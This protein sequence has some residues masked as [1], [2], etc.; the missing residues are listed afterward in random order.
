MTW[1]ITTLFILLV[2]GSAR[3]ILII[4]AM[5]VLVILIFTVCGKSTISKI[6]AIFI[7]FVTKVTLTIVLCLDLLNKRRSNQF[8]C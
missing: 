2:I 6:M 5:Q 1:C 4:L 7:Y 8:D 3:F